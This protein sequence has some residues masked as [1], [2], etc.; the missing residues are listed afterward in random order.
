MHSALSVHDIYVKSTFTVFKDINMCESIFL[1]C[2]ITFVVLPIFGLG[3]VSLSD[4]FLYC[5]GK[6]G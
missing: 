3:T 4:V 2:F 6:I 5:G 1:T